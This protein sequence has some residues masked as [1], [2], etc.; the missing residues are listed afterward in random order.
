MRQLLD[1]FEGFELVREYDGSTALGL[2]PEV[3]ECTLGLEPEVNPD[4]PG[5]AYRPKLPMARL[6]RPAHSESGGDLR[7]GFKLSRLTRPGSLTRN[8][9]PRKAKFYSPT[10]VR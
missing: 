9:R 1:W 4:C 6:A 8:Q 2:E 5:S 10:V 3:M 7:R